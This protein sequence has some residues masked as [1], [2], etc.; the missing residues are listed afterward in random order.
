VRRLKKYILIL[1]IA[2]A[3]ICLSG[4]STSVISLSEEENKEVARYIA[5]VI[6][7]HDINSSCIYCSIFQTAAGWD[8]EV[9]EIDRF[10][11]TP[12]AVYRIL[13]C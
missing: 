2:M 6:M 9:K 7:Q 10:T 1:G 3:G 8:T 11:K 4:C 12:R 13:I 5:D